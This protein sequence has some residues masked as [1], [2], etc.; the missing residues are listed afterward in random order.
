MAASALL[1]LLFPT[2]S[3]HKDPTTARPS[4]TSLQAAD[5]RSSLAVVPG[6]CSPPLLTGVDSGGSSHR[7]HSSRPPVYRARLAVEMNR[8]WL[9]G[10]GQ[11]ERLDPDNRAVNGRIA[12]FLVSSNGQREQFICWETEV[13]KAGK[14]AR[15]IC[16]MKH[17]IPNTKDYHCV[18]IILPKNN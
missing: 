15:A 6:A 3:G 5:S 1:R 13:K 9:E 11:E 8:K 16:I 7:R 18:Q 10:W 4:P 12:G 2:A 14:V 17:P